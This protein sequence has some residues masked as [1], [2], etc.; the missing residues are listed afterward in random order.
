MWLSLTPDQ[1]VCLVTLQF[2]RVAAVG[3]GVVL[4][5]GAQLSPRAHTHTH[6]RRGIRQTRVGCADTELETCSFSENKLADWSQKSL[7]Q[8]QQEGSGD[9]VTDAVDLHQS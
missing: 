8:G 2:G 9:V 1:L 5:L 7:R 4:H 3:G 6:T